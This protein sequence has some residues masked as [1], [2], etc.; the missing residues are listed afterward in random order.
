MPF[1]QK[2]FRQQFI[3]LLKQW[4]E[5]K[6]RQLI[7]L[8]GRYHAQL[9]EELY[10]ECMLDLLLLLDELDTESLVPE[11]VQRAGE[12]FMAELEKTYAKHEQHQGLE[13]WVQRFLSRHDDTVLRKDNE[14]YITFLALHQKRQTQGTKIHFPEDIDQN[15]ALRFINQKQPFKDYVLK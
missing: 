15:Q 2:R 9:P 12:R 13:F 6:Q 4:L 3:N 11:E 5:A 7:E 1:G 10:F 14:F 8:L